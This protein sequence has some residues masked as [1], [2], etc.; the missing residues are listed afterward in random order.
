MIAKQELTAA[1]LL[2][3]A[4]RQI[5]CVENSGEMCKALIASSKSA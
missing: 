2:D 3:F 5:A 1:G 4:G